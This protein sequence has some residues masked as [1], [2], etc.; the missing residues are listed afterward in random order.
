MQLQS[1]FWCVWGPSKQSVS[2]YYDQT[3]LI[4]LYLLLVG[5]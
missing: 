1:K 5:I 4:I 2:R 3:V